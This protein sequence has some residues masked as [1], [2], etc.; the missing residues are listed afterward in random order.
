MLSIR[1]MTKKVDWKRS[2]KDGVVGTAAFAGGMV[3]GTFIDVVSRS[4]YGRFSGYDY[5]HHILLGVV[6][7]HRLH[8]KHLQTGYR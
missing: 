3:V 5:Y 1:N 2:A 7:L 6:V 8:N 4:I